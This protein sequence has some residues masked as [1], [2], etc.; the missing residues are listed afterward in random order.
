VI[1]TLRRDLSLTAVAVA[2]SVLGWAALPTQQG[3]VALADL[4]IVGVLAVR[5]RPPTRDATTR[6]L[7]PTT[8]VNAITAIGIAAV[9]IGVLAVGPLAGGRHAATVVLGVGF[10]VFGILG[11]ALYSFAW[12]AT[13]R[14]TLAATVALVIS[15]AVALWLAVPAFLD[16]IA[17]RNPF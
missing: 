5:Y 11:F 12:V 9:P 14:P 17:G 15:G 1:A 4:V 3:F 16:Q 7:R 6:R 13:R 10:A 8:L 2:I